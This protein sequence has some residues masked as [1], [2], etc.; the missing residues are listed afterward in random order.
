MSN[1]HIVFFRFFPF[2][3]L[4]S[5]SLFFDKMWFV[6]KLFGAKN[7]PYNVQYM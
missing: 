6:P 2:P 4:F 7:F 5:L 1:A 3:F